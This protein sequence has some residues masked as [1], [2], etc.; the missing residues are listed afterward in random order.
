M[1]MM[2]G[3]ASAPMD[4]DE[5]IQRICDGVKPQAEKKAGKTFDVFTA[6]SYTRQTVAGT[7]YFVK[8][9]VGGENHI[10]LRIYEKLPCHGGALELSNIQLSKSSE[11]P[12]VY[13]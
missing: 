8:V 6:K 5:N 7:N 1:S 9:H 11:D 10:H 3:A 13:F 4:A 12:I 2:C